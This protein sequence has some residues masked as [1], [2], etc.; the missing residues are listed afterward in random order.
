MP[1]RRQG[2]GR[3]LGFCFV[4]QKKFPNP[5]FLTAPTSYLT[6]PPKNEIFSRFF[7][8]KRVFMKEKV[9]YRLKMGTPIYMALPVLLHVISFLPLFISV[10]QSPC[11]GSSRTLLSNHLS[12]YLACNVFSLLV[13]VL[14]ICYDLACLLH[15]SHFPTTKKK[16]RGL[17]AQFLDD[18]ENAYPG[19]PSKADLHNNKV[20]K[21][22]RTWARKKRIYV[23]LFARAPRQRIRPEPLRSR[24]PHK[25]RPQKIPLFLG[26]QV[27]ASAAAV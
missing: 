9:D 8:D 27:Q 18:A 14:A 20:S 19:N 25:F 6:P 15:P 23:M 12:Q 24:C 22:P 1:E 17:L 5:C 26:I 21:T 10:S 16:E 13:H 2:S 7:S 11:L 4:F 3:C